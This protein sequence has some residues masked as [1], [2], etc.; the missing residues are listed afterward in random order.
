MR[1]DSGN[2]RLF[3]DGLNDKLVGG[4]GND[5]LYGG[6]GADR[7]EFWRWDDRDK[8]MGFSMSD[9]IVLHN[10]A[11]SMVSVHTSGGSTFI[12][13][14]NEQVELVDFTNGGF[15]KGDIIFD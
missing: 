1:G 5:I 10:V 13:W 11:R 8:V 7:F 9:R 6:S 2:D 14:G 15:D 3:G 4:L 12:E